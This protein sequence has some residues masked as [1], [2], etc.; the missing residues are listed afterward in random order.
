MKFTSKAKGFFSKK[1]LNTEEEK[2]EVKEL[3][4]ESTFEFMPRIEAT[5]EKKVEKISDSEIVNRGIELANSIKSSRIQ[6]SKEER[7]VANYLLDTTENILNQKGSLEPFYV[8]NFYYNYGLMLIG[9][10]FLIALITF[11]FSPIASL[12][13]YLTSLVALVCRVILKKDIAFLSKKDISFNVVNELNSRDK[14][15]NTLIIATNY[16]S[17]RNWLLNRFFTINLRAFITVNIIFILATF[18]SLVILACG[19]NNIGLQSF[20]GVLLFLQMMFCLCFYS[21]DKPNK[22]AKHGLSGLAVSEAIVDYLNQHS[23]LIGDNTK[24][25]FVAVGG[26]TDGANGTKAFIKEHFKNNNDYPNAVVVSFENT[27]EDTILT[28]NSKGKITTIAYERLSKKPIKK[29]KGFLKG[30]GTNLFEN[31][32][33][34][35]V[36]IGESVDNIRVDFN[37]V[38]DNCDLKY[39]EI[40]EKFYCYLPIITD[41]LNELKR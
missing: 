25:V 30:Y 7:E 10:I 28:R 26:G 15:E 35:A 9:V 32:G 29:Q 3:K 11:V 5:E 13:L 14:T 18:I 39:E 16:S 19:I 36:A 34:D 27:V 33:V 2:I 24:V 22:N 40:E 6:G 4:K 37:T 41:I 38:K 23:G 21:F 12:I 20:V 1:Q 17:S 31:M 8:S